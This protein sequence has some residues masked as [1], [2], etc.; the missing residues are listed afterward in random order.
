MD[1]S[2]LPVS[3]SKRPCPLSFSFGLVATPQFSTVTTAF[4]HHASSQ[5]GAVAA[6]DLSVEPPVQ[7]TYGEL[8]RRSVQ[9]ARR[10]Q[11][12]GVAPGSRVPLVV[13]RGTDMLVGILSILAC[14]AQYV[15]LDGSVVPDETL[16]FVLE[17]TGAHAALALKSTIHRLSGTN[18]ANVVVIDDLDDGDEDKVHREEGSVDLANPDD[19]C[20]MIY[21]SGTTGKPKG[22]NVTHR[23]VTNLICQ[24]PGN[25]GIS[26]GKCV[27]Q[28]LNISFDM[29]A[30]ETL[31]CLSN[32]G[33]LIIRGSDWQ[34]TLKEIDVLICTPTILSLYQPQDYPRIKTVATAGEPSSQRLADLWAAHATYF[35]CCGPTETTIVNT[36]HQHKPGLPL[37]IGKPTPNN[38]VYILDKDLVPVDVGQS[39][40]MWAGGLGVSAGYVGLPEITAERYVPDPFAQDGSKMYNTG[41]VCRLNPDGSVHILGRVDDQVK[42]KGFRVEL[43]GIAA[44]LTSCPSVQKATALLVEGE[45]HAFVMPHDCPLPVVKEHMKNR[46]PYYALPSQY[47]PL[48]ILPMTENGKVDKKALRTLALATQD[49]TKCEK[50]LSRAVDSPQPAVLA[51]LRSDSSSS[52]ATQVSTYSDKSDITLV[53]K[54]AGFDLEA[55]LP[56]KKHRKYARGLRYRGLIV[57]RRLLSLVGLFNI[58]AAIA[59]VLTGITRQWLGNITAIN[60]ATAVLVRQE[61]VINA[62]YT[63]ACSVPKSWPLFIRSRCGK[64][65]HLGG[66]HSG[67]AISAGGWL[68]ASNIADIVCMSSGSS[69]PNWGHQSVEAKVLSW[70][71]AVLFAVM[72]SLAWPTV[73]KKYHNLFEMTH[74]FVGW[75]MLALFWAQIVLTNR[76]SAPED[77]SLGSACLKSPSFWLLAVATASVASSWLFLR[78]VPVEAEVLSDHAVRLHFDYTVPVNGSFTRLSYRPLTEWHS[79]ATI[80][81]PQASN[82]RP[83]GYSLVVSNAGD[84]TKSTIHQPP[85]HL[86]TRGVPTCG[87]MRIATL[88]NR[89][90]LIAT[91]SGI[92]PVLGHINNPSCATQLIWST[93]RPEQTFGQDLCNT[94]A[95]KIPNAVIHDTKKLGRPDLV[96]MGFNLAK[97]FGAEAVIIIANE[98]ITK[99]VVYGLETRGVPAYGA[100]WDS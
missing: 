10:L 82:G 52:S 16:Q 72:I 26:P 1:K 29:A 33:T 63:I 36:M 2:L 100:I 88:F 43:D 49:G 84:W 67:A 80:P 99:K 75:T 34:R 15:P 21:T 23:N 14:G 30:W 89:V 8:S 96:K 24:A 87:V 44:S 66:V 61:F 83:R 11:T 22:V 37:S 41:D 25:L 73:R 71:L 18:T 62:L 95:T 46:Q 9:L 42:V 19:G 48:E 74:R 55:A 27:G 59:L 79:F 69:C 35:N 38:T 40:V 39:G 5:P 32:G 57:Y 54:D 31:G 92:G 20:Y 65:Y 78:K 13:K 64:I 85:T 94:I 77:M 50:M 97:S 76:D 90:V 53:E 58:T 51:H 12:L 91:G 81:A 6:R 4:F 45:I 56:Q 98:K 68:L 17:Q 86:W 28:V 60:L 47:H 3:A 7:I 70:I 93:S